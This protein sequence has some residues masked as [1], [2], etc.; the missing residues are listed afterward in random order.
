M[1]KLSLV[2]DQ[3]I[4]ARIAG[5]V[6]AE[7]FDRLFSGIRFDEIDG[8][9][10]YA[11]AQDEDQAAEIEDEF[12]PHIAAVASTVLKKNVDIVVVMPKVLQ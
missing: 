10:L 6:G 2:Q 4:Q 1:K 5:H 7:V 12:A 8:S 9:M 3:A 11:F